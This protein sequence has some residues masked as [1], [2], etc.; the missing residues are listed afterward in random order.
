M[1]PSTSI[2]GIIWVLFHPHWVASILPAMKTED[3]T[4][5]SRDSD[6]FIIRLPEGMREQIAASAKESG[7]SMNSEVVAR[8]Q[9]SYEPP[10]LASLSWVELFKLLQAEAKK[11][12]AEISINIK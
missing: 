7:R 11:H 2:L 12:G 8:L 1:M 6:R 5:V 3:K 10:S 4:A 9:A